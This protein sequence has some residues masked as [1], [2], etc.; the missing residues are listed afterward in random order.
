MSRVHWDIIW[1]VIEMPLFNAYLKF[2]GLTLREMHVSI[3]I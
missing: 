1:N 2:S 3:I